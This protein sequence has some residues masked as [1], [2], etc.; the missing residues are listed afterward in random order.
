MASKPRFTTHQL[1]ELLTRKIQ[2]CKDRKIKFTLTLTEYERLMKTRKCYY[3]DVLMNGDPKSPHRVTLDRI[4]PDLPYQKGN[5]VACSTVANAG[6]NDL[7][8]APSSQRITLSETIA[9]CNKL[10]EINFKPRT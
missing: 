10:I 5:V 3:T 8:E 7:F 6:K 9:M 1:A 2:S 4:N